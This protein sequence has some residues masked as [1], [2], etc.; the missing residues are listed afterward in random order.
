MTYTDILIGFAE[1]GECPGC[2][3]TLED[4][5]QDQEKINLSERYSKCCMCCGW[6]VSRYG[7]EYLF[8]SVPPSIFGPEY[9]KC[10]LEH[11]EHRANWPKPERD[12]DQPDPYSETELVQAAIERDGHHHYLFTPESRCGNC[13]A[14][15]AHKIS[16]VGVGSYN[17]ETTAALCC[18]CFV[19]IFGPWSHEY[20]PV[21]ES[22]IKSIGDN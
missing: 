6:T 7:S 4:I 20:D 14:W 10:I 2:G 21:T 16:E 15:A 3:P 12:E 1:K 11:P 8:G 5:D 22:D 13:N 9:F 18:N 19:E 17:L